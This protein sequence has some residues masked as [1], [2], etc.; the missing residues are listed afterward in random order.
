[1]ASLGGDRCRETGG[2]F[3]C[4]ADP[5]TPGLGVGGVVV[6]LDWPLV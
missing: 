5:Q 1:M 4:G 6:Q 3:A 2:I